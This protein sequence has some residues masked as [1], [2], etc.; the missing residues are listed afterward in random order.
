M[1]KRVRLLAGLA[2]CAPLCAAGVPT[3]G[4]A[5]SASARS[6]KT[7]SVPRPVNG[8]AAKCVASHPFTASSGNVQ[9]HG[10][11]TYHGLNTNV[12][13]GTVKVQLQFN[14]KP[15]HSLCKDATLSLFHRESLGGG[16][17]GSTYWKH[18]HQIC[19]VGPGVASTSFSVHVSKSLFDWAFAGSPYNGGNQASCTFL[20]QVVSCTRRT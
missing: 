19:R 3:A 17:P 20:N 15:G 4:F 9:E 11:Y 1:G 8:P 6:R 14:I 5:A 16:T 10:W 12:C 13:I 18:T 7:V 2:A